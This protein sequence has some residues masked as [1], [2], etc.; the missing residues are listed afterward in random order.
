MNQLTPAGIFCLVCGLSPTQGA[1]RVLWNLLPPFFRGCNIL[2]KW[3]TS[4]MWER[5]FL[6]DAPRNILVFGDLRRLH[7]LG[8]VRVLRS[9]LQ[10]FLWD[11]GMSFLV[12]SCT[13]LPLSSCVS[14]W[15][16]LLPPL[17]P[18]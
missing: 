5:P 13:V 15:L 8:A 7:S 14:L 3:P 16:F 18:F 4:Q 10:P 17:L 2:S 12:L 11:I 9:L 1:V 6:L